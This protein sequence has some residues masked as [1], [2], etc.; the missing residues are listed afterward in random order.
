MAARLTLA[1]TPCSACVS[2]TGA[3]WF[4][5]DAKTPTGQPPI[6]LGGRKSELS[7]SNDS[8]LFRLSPGGP[9]SPPTRGSLLQ[10]TDLAALHIDDVASRSVFA[11]PSLD[12]M[13]HNEQV[14][15]H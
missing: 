7:S 8:S 6:A 4:A 15:Q 9:P 10:F 12:S 2:G 11:R 1:E 5:A 3:Q 14:S 13:A